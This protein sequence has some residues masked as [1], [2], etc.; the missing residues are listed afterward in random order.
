MTQGKRT[1]PNVRYN[2]FGEMLTI[3]EAAKVY[4]LSY[5]TVL[6]RIRRG[7]TLEQAVT[8]ERRHPWRNRPKLYGDSEIP[9][10]I[11]ESVVTC[12]QIR[13]LDSTHWRADGCAGYY[14]HLVTRT[15]DG[16]TLISVYRPT[17]EIS[18]DPRKYT[19]KGQQRNP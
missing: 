19:E 11:L 9:Q 7:E 2:V 14:R 18:G 1:P 4:G 5:D 15:G 17:G 12:A 13:Q 3:V 8:G 6:G 16:Y 10:R